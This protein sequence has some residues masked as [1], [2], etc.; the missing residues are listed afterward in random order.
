MKSLVVL[1]LAVITLA[2]CAEVPGGAERNTASVVD[3]SLRAAAAAA[4]ANRDYKGAVQHFGTLYQ[5]RGD[6]REIGVALARNLRYG[7]QPQAGADIMQAQLSRFPHDA[8]LLIELGKD[9]LAADRMSLAQKALEEGR[10]LAPDR[11]DGHAALGVVLDTQGRGAEA[12]A[13]YLRALE[14]SP[15]NPVVLNNLGLSQAL[16]GKL[17]LAL[18][19]LTRAADLPAANAQ[20]RQNMALLLALKGDAA[21]AEK[22]ARRDLTAEQAKGNVEILKALAGAA[23]AAR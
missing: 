17:D 18:A 11:W 14:L 3:P 12:E 9:Y 23:K 22:L 15:D 6:D 7:G 2:G 8:D 19:T 10:T 4:E 1:G 13:A 16:A 21:Q 20:I 5:R